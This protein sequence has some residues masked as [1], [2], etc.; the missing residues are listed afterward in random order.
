MRMTSEDQYFHDNY[1]ED[2]GEDETQGNE[3]M[4]TDE[5]DVESE[6]ETQGN[7]EMDT[8]ESDVEESEDEAQENEEMDTDGS[9]VEEALIDDE[10]REDE[11]ENASQEEMNEGEDS[12]IEEILVDEREK[13]FKGFSGD[14][15]PYYQNFTS[16]MLFLWISK[17]MICGCTFVLS[18]TNLT[19]FQYILI[20][21]G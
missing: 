5:S 17:H 12:D 13:S 18:N 20:V 15:G 16:M 4:D 21:I 3:G 9:D 8:D 1:N 7:E 10:H 19:Y 14:Y 6:D 11:S 2:E